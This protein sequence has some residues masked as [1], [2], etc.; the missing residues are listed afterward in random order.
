MDGLPSGLPLQTKAPAQATV[1]VQRTLKSSIGCVGIGLHS[2]RKLEMVLHPARVGT[3]IIFRRTDAEAGPDGYE[4]PAHFQYIADTRQ[5]TVLARPE[6][7]ELRIGTV[8]HVMAAL[9]GCG[10]S[11]AVVSVDGPELPIL[12]GSAASFV[13]L[14]D[15]AGIV[16][17]GVTAPMI[18]VLRPVGIGHGDAFAELHPGSGD[19]DMAMSI[20]FDAAVIGHQAL[21]LRLTPEA[22]RA[23]L[24]RAR[25][26]TLVGEVASL[27]AAGLALG[28]NLDN[29]VVVDDARVLNP[30]GL[31]MPD[32]FV[33]HK[34]LDAIGDL[35]LAGAALRGRFLAHRS[36][37]TMNHHLLRALFA[38]RANWRLLPADAV[39]AD[40]GPDARMTD[41]GAGLPSLGSWQERRLPV[42]AAPV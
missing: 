3:G 10:I 12:D 21:S 42:A 4:I 7:P 6:R 35:A 9:A 25:T 20:A 39:R 32:E 19:L 17:Q 28:G 34:L 24:A 26:F 16:D 13:F 41:G 1:P 2:G 22:F 31:R 8:E 14:I 18:E 40:A 33:R 30:G 37:H 38:D 27:H 23:E 15:C 11:N 29:A 36:G 5:C